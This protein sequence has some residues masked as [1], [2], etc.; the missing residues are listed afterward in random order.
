MLPRSFGLVLLLLTMPFPIRAATTQQGR[1]L[2]VL[3]HGR[4]QHKIRPDVLEQQWRRAFRNGIVAHGGDRLLSETRDVQFVHYN[5]FYGERPQTRIP[6][7]CTAPT[8][9]L[10]RRL[11]AHLAQRTAAIEHRKRQGETVPATEIM[12]LEDLRARDRFSTEIE[13]GR[14]QT[15][16]EINATP[17]PKLTEMILG[18]AMNSTVVQ[19]AVL[20]T[21]CRDVRAYLTD[22]ELR[23]ATQNRLHEVLELAQ[24]QNRPV[25]VVAHSM[26]SLI[27]F[28][29]FHDMEPFPKELNR[30]RLAHFISIGSQL[31]SH[32]LVQRFVGNTFPL[33]TP[34]RIERWTHFQ[35]VGDPI[36]PGRMIPAHYEPRYDPWRYAERRVMRTL[37]ALRPMA[38][39]WVLNIV[40]PLTSSYQKI[41][42]QLELHS[43]MGY[44]EHPEI[45]RTIL[46]GWC[47]AFRP[48]TAPTGCAALQ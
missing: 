27:S 35:V 2:I 17:D 16:Q 30:L 18:G 19:S 22:L 40:G 38:L 9:G 15:L 12:A 44:L 32:R 28:D 23:C 33:R 14:K 42:Q 36:A 39:P 26:G 21:T 7:S 45:A 3:I 34:R 47:E 11:D 13:V 6:S 29:Y 8:A 4:D 41:Q 24:R 25:L 10:R 37:P 20:A 48:G 5:D 1:P 43:A 46:S 31:G